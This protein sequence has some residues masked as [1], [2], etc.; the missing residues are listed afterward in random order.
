MKSLR[1]YLVGI[2]RYTEINC[3]TKNRFNNK[4]IPQLHVWPVSFFSRGIF[5]QPLGFVLFFAISFVSHRMS[6]EKV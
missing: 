3:I 6:T 2:E 5:V 4:P 1:A